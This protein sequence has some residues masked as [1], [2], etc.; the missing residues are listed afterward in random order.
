MY[1]GVKSHGGLE[2]KIFGKYEHVWSGHYHTRSDKGNITYV[3]TPYELT[4]QDC[5]DP[6]GFHI[7][8]T[9]SRKLEFVGNDYTIFSRLEYDDRN[10]E[11]RIEEASR[12]RDKFVR[13]V[14]VHKS[15][16]TKFDSFITALQSAGALEV[17]VVEDVASEFRTGEIDENIDLEDTLTV[18]T[19]Y[20][21]SVQSDTDKDKVKDYMK[22]LYIEALHVEE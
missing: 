15:D 9:E 2:S 19:N 13:V 20:V 12:Y 21:D 7:F 16:I 5:G 11:N 8:D 22:T 4:W 10:S 3:G 1:R 17:K 14:V 18:V 6:R